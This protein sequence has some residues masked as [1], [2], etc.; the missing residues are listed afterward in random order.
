[1]NP[2]SSTANF[3]LGLTIILLSTQFAIHKSRWNLAPDLQYLRTCY[4]SNRV[5]AVWI[6][7]ICENTEVAGAVKSLTLCAALKISYV[8]LHQ[9]IT[10]LSQKW[11]AHGSLKTHYDKVNYSLQER[12]SCLESTLLSRIVFTWHDIF[13]DTAIQWERTSYTLVYEFLVLFSQFQDWRESWWR[14]ERAEASGEVE[15]VMQGNNTW[16]ATHLIRGH[17]LAEDLDN[18]PGRYIC[19]FQYLSK[20]FFG[21]SYGIWSGY[22]VHLLHRIWKLVTTHLWSMYSHIMFFW[23]SWLAGNVNAIARAEISFSRT[24]TECRIYIVEPLCHVPSSPHG[25]RL[26]CLTFR[27]TFFVLST[28]VANH[29]TTV[30]FLRHKFSRGYRATWIEFKL[31]SDEVAHEQFQT[32]SGVR[33]N[34]QLPHE[35]IFANHRQITA[36]TVDGIMLFFCHL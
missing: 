21:N 30:F 9:Y 28:A 10:G 35:H 12:A 27:L 22:L 17:Q 13:T 34:Y 2:D 3:M 24:R 16:K 20:A 6:E 18:E 15:L 11:I 5:S 36:T 7:T 1:M 8:D 32:I 31:H 29:R 26:G 33:C 19:Q 4:L 14:A 23:W 25:Q